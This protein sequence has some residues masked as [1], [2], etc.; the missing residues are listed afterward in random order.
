VAKQRFTKKQLAWR[1]NTPKPRRSTK[2]MFASVLLT[3]QALAMVFAGLAMFGLRGR[4]DG[5]VPALVACLILAAA[6]IV[7]CAFLKKSW[8]IGLGW[9]LQVVTV[10]FGILEPAMYVVGVA[11]LLMWAYCVI[12]GGQMDRIDDEREREQREWEAAHPEQR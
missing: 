6:M 2:I 7:A 12:K 1:P 5:G 9:A 3:L 11:F 10:A 8:G 4:L